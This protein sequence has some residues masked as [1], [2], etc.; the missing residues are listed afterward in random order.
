[1]KL[2]TTPPTRRLLAVGCSVLF[3]FFILLGAGWVIVHPW[4]LVWTLVWTAVLFSFGAMLAIVAILG[5]RRSNWWFDYFAALGVSLCALSGCLPLKILLQQLDQEQ[6]RLGLESRIFLNRALGEVTRDGVEERS[7]YESS[8][9]ARRLNAVG[10]IGQDNEGSLLWTRYKL[11]HLGM[12]TALY[13]N[14]VTLYLANVQAHPPLGARASV[15]T[16]VEL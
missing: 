7:K 1:M 4:D 15:E 16:E 12:L 8:F 10:I 5:D 11:C 3:A 13:R 6:T 9:L 2:H 14:C